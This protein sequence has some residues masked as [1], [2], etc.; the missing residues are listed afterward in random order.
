MTLGTFPVPLRTAA[1]RPTAVAAPARALRTAALVAGL[2]MLL[3][4]VLAGWANFTVIEALVTEG[5]PTRTARDLLASDGTFRLGI[6]SLFAVAALDV[7]VAWALRAFFAPTRRAVA[8]AAAWIRTIYAG[9][10]A[11]AI[12][13]LAGALDVLTTPASTAL[14]TSEVHLEAWRR[15]EA[16][17]VIWDAGLVAFGIHLALLGYLALRASYVPRV[18]GWLLAIAAAGYLLDSLVA[19]LAPGALPE[20]AVFTFIG[21]VVLL[22]WLLVKGRNVTAGQVQAVPAGRA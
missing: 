4:A 17:H 14:S 15:I 6:V 13:Q 8:T 12:A 19:L 21:E 2:G 18:V 16:F 10:F 9:V 1:P 5:D 22:G 11:V 20:V 7:I 3:M